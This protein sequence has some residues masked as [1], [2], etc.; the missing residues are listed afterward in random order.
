MRGMWDTKEVSIE[1]KLAY[2]Y[3]N[4]CRY[5]TKSRGKIM[6]RCLSHTQHS[7]AALNPH[8][9]LTL[10]YR[11]NYCAQSPRPSL[12]GFEATL[13][14]LSTAE[15]MVLNLSCGTPHA[16]NIPSSSFL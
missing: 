10:N 8:A 14:S 1:S 2:T 9:L 16:A 6:S 5:L 15:Q 11:L 13:S 4:S 12:Q 3:E 7:T